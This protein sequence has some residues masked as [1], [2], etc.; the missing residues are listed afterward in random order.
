M[1]AE[2]DKRMRALTSMELYER[3]LTKAINTKVVP[4]ASYAMNV[5]DLNQ[6]QIDDFNKLIKKALQN[7]GMHC[8]QAS[9]E[10]LYLNVK[11]RRK[12]LKSRK[13]VQKIT[14]LRVACY[15]AY[16]NS[17]WIKAA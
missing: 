3:N 16:Q 10:R 5:C 11:G 7:K 12:R 13:N 17:P 8:R 1:K 6:K 14:K 2:I 4:V 15:M 9:D